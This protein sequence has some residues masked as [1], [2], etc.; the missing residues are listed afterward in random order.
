VASRLKSGKTKNMSSAGLFIGTDEDI[1][2]GGIWEISFSQP[3]SREIIVIGR[4]VW[5]SDDKEDPGYGVEVYK[6]SSSDLEEIL[7]RAK[8]GGWIEAD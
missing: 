4:A 8:R 7:R 2:I 5:R 3:D 1:E 6:T